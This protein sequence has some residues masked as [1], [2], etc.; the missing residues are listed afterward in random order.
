MEHYSEKYFPK[1][2]FI[3]IFLL[4]ISWILNWSLSGLR[5]H[6]AFF[7][8]WFG[9]CLTVDGIV[10]RR[11][12]TSLIR[13]STKKYIYLF[14]IS[15]PVWW[16]FELINSHTQNWLYDGKQF[17]S[18]WEYALYATFSFSTVMPAVFET[19]ELISSFKWIEKFQKGPKVST[20]RNSINAIFVIGIL[21][22]A[23]LIIFPKYF[24]VFVWLSLFFI[25][26]PINFKLKNRTLLWFTN[27]GD[28][29]PVFSLWIGCLIC[30]YFWEFW[31]YYS[32]PKWIYN[33]PFVEF[34][35]V[36]EMPIIGFL[37]YLPFSLELF[38]VY[39]FISA[40]FS[41]HSGKDYFV[42]I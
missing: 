4:T 6:W 3:G 5:T 36:F 42:K 16:L 24:Y 9:Y 38:A 40:L 32:Y 33:V 18:D 28:W 34:A 17:F 12:G 19:S 14:L 27:K 21:M 25:L 39:S 35:K 26:E 10:F 30:G 31:N 11:T 22:L 29:R 8:L 23:S 2:F 37:G 7:P 41:L 20:T 15:A 1:H 13:R